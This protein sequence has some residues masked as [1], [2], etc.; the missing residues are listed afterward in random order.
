MA[1]D[2]SRRPLKFAAASV[3]VPYIEK[4]GPWYT[5]KRPAT[6][7]ELASG[8]EEDT[9]YDQAMQAKYGGTAEGYRVQVTQELA[10]KGIDIS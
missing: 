1:P 4:A 6:P 7:T 3:A 9:P 10:K 2:F 8:F 5:Y